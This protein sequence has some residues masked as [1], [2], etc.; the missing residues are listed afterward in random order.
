[1]RQFLAWC[2]SVQDVTNHYQAKEDPNVLT[3]WQQE[4]E[5]LCQEVSPDKPSRALSYADF[6]E[7]FALFAEMEELDDEWI[8]TKK[9]FASLFTADTYEAETLAYLSS[10]D[11]LALDYEHLLVYFVFRYLMNAAYDYDVI[12]YGKLVIVSTLVVRDMDTARFARNA[13]HFSR[14]DRIDVARIF[15]KEVEH[16]EGNADAL[17]EMCMMEEIASVDALYRQI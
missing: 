10:P 9:E 8:N 1:M 12:T 11:C 7:R 3:A 16:S 6:E 5:G 2:E 4:H 14:F 13:R 17:K 15:S